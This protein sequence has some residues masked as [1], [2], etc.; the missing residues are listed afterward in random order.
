M[1]QVLR[2]EYGKFLIID[3]RFGFEYKGGHFKSAINITDPDHLEELLFRGHTVS[4]IDSHVLSLRS[5]FNADGEL[6]KYAFSNPKSLIIIFHC[7]YSQ[8]RGPRMYRHLRHLDRMA[9]EHNYPE[10]YYPN[11][12]VLEKGYKGFWEDVCACDCA[13]GAEFC[14]PNQYVPMND[15][16]YSADLSSSWKHMKEC[17]GR[18]KGTSRRR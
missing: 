2:G 3:C 9:H 13:I 17:W 16:Q 15:E 14:E 5:K 11:M 18:R 12:Y 4:D 7:E 10:L 1:M 8:K 6:L